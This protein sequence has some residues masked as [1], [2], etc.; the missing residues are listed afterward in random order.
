MSPESIFF[1]IRILVALV[2]YA[3]LG[4]ILFSLWRDIKAR[5]TLQTEA[6]IAHLVVA[7]G[8]QRFQLRPSSEIGRA[9]GTLDYSEAGHTLWTGRR[10]TPFTI[11]FELDT[12]I[13]FRNRLIM[14]NRSTHC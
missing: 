1:A 14:W 2:L 10:D 13:P 5:Q 3:F 11:R 12:P 9:A 4:M 8:Q 7:D 6:P